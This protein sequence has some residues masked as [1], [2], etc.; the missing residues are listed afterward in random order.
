MVYMVVSAS[1]FTVTFFITKL[2]ILTMMLFL[3]PLHKTTDDPIPLQKGWIWGLITF[4]CYWYWIVSL[5]EKQS[6]YSTGIVLWACAVIWCSLFAAIWLYFFKRYP[7]LSTTLFFLLVIKVILFPLG[8]IDG[9]PF[10]NPLVLL[11]HYSILLQPL[12]YLK[13]M[14]MLMLIFGLQNWIAVQ[15]KIIQFLYVGILCCLGLILYQDPYD[16][17]QIAGT[18]I[19]TPWW[20]HQK[21]GAMFDGYRLAHEITKLD[22]TDCAMILTPESTFCFDVQEYTKF[23][24]IW[25]QSA[26]NI[27][28]LLGCHLFYKGFPH[29]S[30]VVLHN[31]EIVHLYFKQHRM[32]FLEKN[33]WFEYFL[34]KPL[35]SPEFIPQCTKIDM[36]NDLIYISGKMYQL[37][38]CSELFSESKTIWGYPILFLWNDTWFCTHYM[39]NIA[40]L[41]INY[42]KHKYRTTIYHIATNGNI[43]LN[44]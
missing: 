6:L 7:T 36:Q 8:Q 17:Y 13:D 5:F 33:V 2:S 32:P 35:L 34:D 23:I 39:K 21:K 20:Y 29:N 38:I 43:G 9:I 31:N 27:P 19:I 44:N 28:I 18:K 24:N 1:L 37:C 41:F 22:K 30:L 26:E 15:K 11:A 40:L 4:G 42:C 25:C 14:G 12:Y 16:N 10:I 3:I